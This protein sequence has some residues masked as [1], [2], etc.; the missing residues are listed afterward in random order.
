M[1]AASAALPFTVD[2]T[3]PAAPTGLADAASVGGYVNLASDTSAQALTGSAEANATVAVSDDGAQLG[4]TTANASG[5]WSYGLGVLAD[6]AYSLTATATDAAGNVSG[7]SAAL[8]FAVDTTP[9][10]APSGLADAAIVGGFVNLANDTSAQALTG[11]AE[12]G[13]TVAVSD[14]GTQLGTTTAN[15]SGAWSYGL[16]V[17]ANGAH[18]L[19][20]TA[21]DAA[22]NVGGASAALA[23][24]VDTTPPAAPTGLADASIVGGFVNKADD[25]SAQTLIGSAEAGAT[26]AVYDNGLQLGATTADASGAWSYGLGVLA[27]GA[28][29]LT[30]TATDAAGNGSG[31]S[32]ALAFT[33]D[34]LAPPPAIASAAYKKKAWT[35]KGTAT[36]NATVT[37]YDGSKTLGTTTAGATGAWT[38]RTK[39]NA[40]AARDFTA[41]APDALGNVSPASGALIE[42]TH[43]NNAFDLASADELLSLAGLYG[44]GG[45]D[46]VDLAQAAALTDADFAH[47]HGVHTLT[48]A[49]GSRATL[50]ADAAKAGIAAVKTGAG[51]TS[52]TGTLGKALTIAV[53]A[54]GATLTLAGKAKFTV[55]GLKP[56]AHDII[57]GFAKSSD[58]IDL[59]A[60]AGITTF[61][62]ALASPTAKVDA[63][64]VAYRYDPSLDATLLFANAGPTAAVQTNPSLIEIELAGGD[65]KLTAANFKLA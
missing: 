41:T 22:D 52:I 29:R 56:G 39:E 12:A 34:T 42:G 37:V 31:A 40:S 26:V 35:L 15:P 28:H 4:T 6:G 47:V 17:L 58:V 65:F 51:A 24:L 63:D 10:A 23:F 32:S 16:G 1:G 49:Q 20:A 9:P 30:A 44:N 36:A 18:S 11:S 45:M 61:E 7:A 14:N 33:V 8:A 21:T 19:T 62:G 43:G 64:S 3:P 53:A 46:T 50:G 55:T 27:D 60:S 38:F 25:T 48:L 57:S 54:L 2:T 13:A 59:S 5:A